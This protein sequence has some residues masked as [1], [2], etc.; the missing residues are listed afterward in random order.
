MLGRLWRLLT[1]FGRRG[2]ERPG[3]GRGG[4]LVGGGLLME[5]HDGAGEPPALHWKACHPSTERR[6]KAQL[7]CPRGHGMVLKRHSIAE[8]GRVRPS[9]VCR[10]PRCDF[11]AIVKLD[12]WDR[13]ALR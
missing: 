7:T 12:R 2:G 8:D 9:V 1:G 3:L 11:H 4:R 10:S 5:R 13:G 6:F